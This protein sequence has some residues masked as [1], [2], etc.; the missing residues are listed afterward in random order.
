MKHD[1]QKYNYEILG[2]CFQINLPLGVPQKKSKLKNKKTL[3]LKVTLSLNWQEESQKIKNKINLENSGY[4]TFCN[5]NYFITLDTKFSK[6]EIQCRLL[7]QA[8]P[9]ILASRGDWVLHA[10]GVRFQDQ[11][12]LFTGLSGAGKSTLAHQFV[13]VGAHFL[14]DESLHIFSNGKDLAIHSSAPEIRLMNAD[15]AIKT[16][17]KGNFSVAFGKRRVPIKHRF[18]QVPEKLSTIVFLKKMPSTSKIRLKKLGINSAL[19]VLLTNTYHTNSDAR[20]IHK[21]YWPLLNQALMHTNIWQLDLP[22]RKHIFN[23]AKSLLQQKIIDPLNDP[24]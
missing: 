17:Q 13:S 12:L 14:G 24:T 9:L 4:I 1:I 19:K 16:D 23:T 2:Y 21:S 18:Q 5:N 7:H 8:L 6:S 20:K 3:S 11:T 10:S 22:H 15:C